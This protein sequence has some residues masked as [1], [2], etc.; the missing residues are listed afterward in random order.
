MTD[1][2]K[3]SLALLFRLHALTIEGQDEGPEAEAI[4]DHME[5][6]WY[7]MTEVEQEAVGNVSAQLWAITDAIGAATTARYLNRQSVPASRAAD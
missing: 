1:P 2:M 5:E 3:R 7:K 4:R 6:P